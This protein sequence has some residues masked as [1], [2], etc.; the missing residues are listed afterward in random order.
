MA[1]FFHLVDG[2]LGFFFFCVPRFS[3]ILI[4]TAATVAAKMYFH[5]TGAVFGG[6]II[7][8]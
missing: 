8:D 3:G 5:T 6:I 1:K 2:F 4:S 7:V